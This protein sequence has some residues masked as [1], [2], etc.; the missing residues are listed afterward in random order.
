MLK[1]LFQIEEV[2]PRWAKQH[3]FRIIRRELRTFFQ[4]PFF[5]NKYKP[6]YYLT[7]ED[8]EQRQRTGWIRLGCWFIIGFI[9]KIE[10]QWED[11]WHACLAESK[12]SETTKI[13]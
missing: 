9:E 10:V 2:L 3:G 8:Q 12:A 4:G 1:T 5:L 11:E 6:V 13:G 7:V